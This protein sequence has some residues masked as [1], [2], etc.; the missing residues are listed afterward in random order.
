VIRHCEAKMPYFAVPRFIEV[1][2]EL[3]R[4]PVG[5]ILKFKLREAGNG[6][7]TWDREAHGVDVAR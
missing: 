6:P 1:V 2:A 4:S 3:P 7:A 5:R